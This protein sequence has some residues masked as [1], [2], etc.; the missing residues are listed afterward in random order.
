MSA[1]GRGTALARLQMLWE[2]VHDTAAGHLADIPQLV[3]G[4]YFF[5]QLRRERDARPHA[6]A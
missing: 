1:E 5:R 6:A 3:A 2:A 4:L